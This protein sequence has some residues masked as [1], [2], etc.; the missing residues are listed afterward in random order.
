MK[1]R[2]IVYLYVLFGHWRHYLRRTLVCYSPTREGLKFDTVH[3]PLITTEIQ[4]HASCT[5]SYQSVTVQVLSWGCMSC[6]TS[7]NL[8]FLTSNDR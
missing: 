5:K 1:I 6:L 8:V 7:D 3:L 2:G 4:T